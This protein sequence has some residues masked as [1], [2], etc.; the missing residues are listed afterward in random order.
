MSNTN[1]SE[2]TKSKDRF[3][4]GD[5]SREPSNSKPQYSSVSYSSKFE[6]ND[7]EGKPSLKESEKEIKDTRRDA[8]IIEKDFI[9]P[10]ALADE[11]VL[12]YSPKTK[13]NSGSM[14]SKH[15]IPTG[16]QHYQH[17]PAIS[18][19][20]IDESNYSYVSKSIT[21]SRLKPNADLLY[22][23][24]ESGSKVH[25]SISTALKKDSRP[26]L[27]PSA[28]KNLREVD[29]NRILSPRNHS[30]SISTSTSGVIT[31]NNTAFTLNG[32]SNN[33][34][35][36]NFQSNNNHT[37]SSYIDAL[38]G[39]DSENNNIKM[40]FNQFYKGLDVKRKNYFKGGEEDNV[41]KSI[42]KL[43]TNNL[44]SKENFEAHQ[45]MLSSGSFSI[46]KKSSSELFNLKKDDS[47]LVN[48]K[49]LD[50]LLNNRVSY[51]SKS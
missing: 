24:N 36:T 14:T 13:I 7:R 45:Y 21:T 40:Q 42:E 47:R 8:K 6:K 1:L 37:N 15:K 26:L 35:N 38:K 30:G 23:R 28:A 19:T 11:K 3:I 33:Q 17:K 34:A 25:E 44:V 20:E 39:P 41:V 32:T 46:S 48:S 12:I 22:T 43:H 4:P 31:S 51:L 29:I 27:S 50:K 2:N 9:I 10:R 5:F 49:F 18:M 16:F